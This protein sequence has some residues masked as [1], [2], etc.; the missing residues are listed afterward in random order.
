MKKAGKI[1]DAKRADD[2]SSKSNWNIRPYLAMGLIFFIV[3]CCCLL[4]V[5]LVF[6]FDQIKG[7]ISG[8]TDIAQPILYGLVIGYLMNPVMSWIERG[9]LKLLKRKGENPKTRRLVRTVSSILAVFVFILVIAALLS[10]VIPQVVSNISNL[11]DILPSQVNEFIAHMSEWRFGNE[12][13]MAFIETY[14]T[15]VVDWLEDWLRNSFLPQA[16]DYAVSITSGV[17]NVLNV[18][19][20][21]VIG[22]IVSI[23]VMCE[24][25]Q[26]E[27]Q[28][29][30]IIFSVLPSRAANQV[31]QIFHTTNEIL[32]G[33]IKGKMVDSLIIGIICYIGLSII[34]MPYTLLVSVIVGVTNIIPFFGPFIGA[35]PCTFLILLSDP[36]YAMYFVIFVVILQQVDGNIIGPKILGDSTGLSSFWVMFA[37]LVGS[38]LFGV[39]GMLLGCP[40]FA[41][42]YYIV[43][44]IV[45]FLLRKKSMPLETE[46]Y[47]EATGADPYSSEL[48]YDCYADDHAA[49]IRRKKPD[50]E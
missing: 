50:E 8:F 23:Y 3:F 30:K 10:M 39:L 48:W 33:F 32:G 19:K 31:I 18:V 26:F 24:K 28:S 37:I 16:K 43:Q 36:L 6:R 9:I 35:I 40:V 34:K 7:A 22:L 29:K 17:I 5:F 46:V 1:P 38:G 41:V 20:N 13:V 49:A 25:E 14:L 44:K 2:S 4:V 47:I 11:V 45:D 15:S 27:G 21:I 42:I 12:D